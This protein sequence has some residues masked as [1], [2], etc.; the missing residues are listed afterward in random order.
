MCIQIHASTKETQGASSNRLIGA[1]VKRRKP[2]RKKSGKLEDEGK[3]FGVRLRLGDIRI[4][5]GEK[6]LK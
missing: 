6:L 1:A 4:V 3:D 2:L 5:G